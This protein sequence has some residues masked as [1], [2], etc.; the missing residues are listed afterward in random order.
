MQLCNRIYYSTVHWRLNMFRAAY[1]SSS[2]ALTLFAASGLHNLFPLWLDYGR[3]QHAYVNQRLQIQLELLMMSG[4]PLETCWAF[5]GRWNNKFYYKVA[6]C[7]L[8][9]LSH[10]T[11]HGSMNIELC[12]VASSWINIRIYLRCTDPWTLKMWKWKFLLWPH[13]GHSWWVPCC[14][15]SCST[16]SFMS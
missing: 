3:S 1:R 8:F 12:N 9:L 10:T 14:F 7:W 5:N 2:G 13:P 15:T 16:L 4:M 11:M 6:S